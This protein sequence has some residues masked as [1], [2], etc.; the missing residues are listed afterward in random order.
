MVG[1]ELERLIALL[2]RLPGLGPRSARRAALH[3][4]KR[5]EALM[6]PLADALAA[7]AEAV[8]PCSICNAWDERDPCAICADAQRD[9]R[10][11]CVVA[12]VGDLWA[13]ERAGG[14]R[15][16]YHVLDGLL[17]AIDGRDADAIGVARLVARA[18]EGAV[19]EVVLALSATV[20]GQTTADVVAD[21]LAPLDVAV[22][23]LAQ[24][25]P[26][27]GE[28]DRLDDGT[29]IAALRARRAAS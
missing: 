6:T 13:L 15:G 17:S 5:R 2:G 19:D 12:E 9:Q 22:S 23:R 3:L 14:W 10:S 8:R 26:F 24:G 25:V 16:V 4:L 28:L 18:R 11:I 20:E 21:A 27:G 29:L 1:P 7:A